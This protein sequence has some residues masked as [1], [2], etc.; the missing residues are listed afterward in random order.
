[1]CALDSLSGCLG[2]CDVSRFLV[3]VRILCFQHYRVCRC[4]VVASGILMY[5]SCKTCVKFL[6]KNA[7]EAGA[8][9]PFRK[10]SKSKPHVGYI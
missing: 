2:A 5:I 9:L 3:D 6:I 1:M 7:P 4:C 8:W 10:K